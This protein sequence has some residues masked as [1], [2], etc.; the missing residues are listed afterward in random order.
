MPV[1]R[2][3]HADG[4]R[5]RLDL[6]RQELRLEVAESN[7][8][9]L[10]PVAPRTKDGPVSAATLLLKAKQFDDGLY[11]A[12]ELAAQ[13]GAG[14]FPGKASLLRSLAATLSAGVAFAETAAFIRAACELG[15]VSVE[16][17]AAFREAIPESLAGFLREDRLSKPLGFYTWTPELSAIFRQ[18][19]LLQEPLD[20]RLADALVQAIAQT[21]GA[22]EAHAAWLRL[23]ARLTNPPGRPGLHNAPDEEGRRAFFPPSRSFEV[24]IFERLYRNK[25]IPEGFDLM[26]ELIRRV[27]SGDIHLEPTDDAG[28]Y[29]RQA[30]SLEPLVVPDRM[31]ERGR[32]ELG[33]RYR[34]HLEDLFRGSLALARETHVKQGGGGYGGAGRLPERPIWV[35]PSLSVEPLPTLFER[36][37]ACYRFVR[38]ALAEAFG[39]D[40]LGRLHRLRPG[41]QVEANLAEEMDGMEKLFAGAAATARRQIGLEKTSSSDDQGQSFTAWRA[42]LTGDEDVSR[43]VRMMVP[44]FYDIERRKIKVWALLGWQAVPVDVSYGAPPAILAVESR[45]RPAGQA[46]EVLF[47]SARYEFAGPVVAEV[48]VAQLLDRDEFRR[49][50]DRHRTR[51]A[52]L[53]NLR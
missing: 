8:A 51:A 44:V 40:A 9:R 42:R 27:R 49:H 29:D 39:A 15:G 2:E 6:S 19:R 3:V 31:P 28:C 18:D 30:W 32:L 24:S 1:I 38:S 21:P 12:V 25:P 23:A 41:G 14:N 17:P 4:W 36:R 53:A 20:A 52:I 5:V 13:H 16:V 37:A 46:P 48:Y 50:C 35:E 34:R 7:R 33:K 22:A 45:Q 47:S 26:G 10:L 43:D 11:A